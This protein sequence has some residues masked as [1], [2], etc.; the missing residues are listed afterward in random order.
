[1]TE[2]SG[3]GGL[4]S[5]VKL[6]MVPVLALSL[7]GIA[8]GDDEPAATPEG[9]SSADVGATVENIDALLDDV[10]AAYQEGDAEEASELAAEAYLENYEL[11]EH[12]VEEAD[13]ELNEELELLLGAQLRREID[14]GA[15]ESDIE[16]MIEEARALLDEAVTAVEG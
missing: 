3:G 8:C 16:A 11:I 13:E 10:L 12:D 7:T 9:E 5:L 14:E 2:L 6:L 4:L 1:V 15:S